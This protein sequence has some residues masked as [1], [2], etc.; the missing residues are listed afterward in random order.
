MCALCKLLHRCRGRSGAARGSTRHIASNIP[1]A[2]WDATSGARG[3]HAEA[4]S[5]SCS[6]REP[7]KAIRS[8]RSSATGGKPSESRRRSWGC[9][10]GRASA[11]NGAMSQPK[12]NYRRLDI[13]CVARPGGWADQCSRYVGGCARDQLSLS[14]TPVATIVLFQTHGTSLAYPVWDGPTKTGR[15]MRRYRMALEPGGLIAWLVVGLIAGWL[16]G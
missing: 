13:K 10:L 4:C 15:K 7:P 3:W 2:C 1:E 5:R 14:T 9:S 8:L 12:E 16:A 6:G 11:V